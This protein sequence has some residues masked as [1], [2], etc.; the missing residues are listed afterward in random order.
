MRLILIAALLLTGLT[1]TAEP[2]RIALGSCNNQREEQDFWDRIL[3]KSP[4]LFLALGDNV[5][6]DRRGDNGWE[7]SAEWVREA[8]AQLGQSPAYQR[9]ASQVPIYPIWDDHDYGINDAGRELAFKEQS[10]KA[11]TDFYDF[12]QENQLEDREGLYYAFTRKV[13]GLTVQFLMLDTRW[14][15]SPLYTVDGRIEG[16]RGRYVADVSDDAEILGDQQWSWLAYQLRRPAD[17]RIIASSIQVL[18][19]SHHF[20]RWG[21]M[22]KQRQRLYD[23]IEETQAQ[24]VLFVSGDRHLGGFYTLED[25]APYPLWEL[26]ASSLNRGGW[27]TQNEDGPYEILSTYG[28][29]NFAL[30]EIDPEVGTIAMSLNRTEDGKPVRAVTLPIHLLR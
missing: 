25:A 14:N 1:A 15:R 21:N 8:Y 22:P 27:S 16:R 24:G 18:A 11:L 12:P 29:E 7:G 3:E 9:F 20:E 26:T 23:L 4:D 6:A 30:I 10:R 28:G 19:D 13:G 5:Y 17:V 2:L